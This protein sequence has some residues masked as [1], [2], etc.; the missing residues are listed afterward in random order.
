MCSINE[1]GFYIVLLQRARE[2]SSASWIGGVKHIMCA[3]LSS[4]PAVGRLGENAV[5]GK[6][7]PV[8]GKGFY[9]FYSKQGTNLWEF[10]ENML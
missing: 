1:K 9:F 8:N 3:G 2:R 10:A 4:Y 5:K 7:S 6:V